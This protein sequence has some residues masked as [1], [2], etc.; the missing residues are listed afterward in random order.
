SVAAAAVPPVQREKPACAMLHV[1]PAS[2]LGAL[3]SP[4]APPSDQRS[5]CHTP[6][7]CSGLDGSISMRGSTSVLTYN[8]PVESLSQPGG[9]AAVL[10]TWIV[11]SDGLGAAHI[12]TRS[13]P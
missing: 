9:N 3:K 2:K 11:M 1:S 6:I 10:V 4:L 5:C 7:R 13:G 12:A 8:V